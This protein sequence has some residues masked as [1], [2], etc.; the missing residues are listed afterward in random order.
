M[1]LKTNCIPLSEL[2]K[3][4]E[5]KKLIYNFKYKYI[6][7]KRIY[8]KVT[9]CILLLKSAKKKLVRSSAFHCLAE[10]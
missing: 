10:N 4:Y 5:W 3:V 9:P 1:I 8:F 6:K 7:A 2:N